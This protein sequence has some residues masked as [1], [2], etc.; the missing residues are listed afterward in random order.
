MSGSVDVSFIQYGVSPVSESAGWSSIGGRNNQ[1]MDA[2]SPLDTRVVSFN[3]LSRNGSKLDIKEASSPMTLLFPY[4]STQVKSNSSS[5]VSSYSRLSFNITCPGKSGHEGDKTSTKAL[6]FHKTSSS[7]TTKLTTVS[8]VARNTATGLAI[9]SVP[10]GS[11]IGFRNI[12]C[13]ARNTS[14]ILC[15][16]CPSI[17]VQPIC[18]FWNETKNVWSSS[19]CFVTENDQFSMSCSCNHTTN[20]AARFVALADMQEDLFSSESLSALSKPEELIRL[21]PHVF[22]IISVISAFV[23]IS[24]IITYDLDVRASRLFYETLRND[25]EVKFLERIE[26]LKGN[27]F[28][29]DRVMDDKIYRLRDKIS[30]ARLQRQAKEIAESEGRYYIGNNELLPSGVDINKFDWTLTK[31]T[32]FQFYDFLFSCFNVNNSSHDALQGRAA[33]NDCKLQS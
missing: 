13:G 25:P 30:R 8:I 27:V 17:I 32:S 20:F 5:I 7:V 21:F 18:A 11:P 16:E 33:E 1:V 2:S 14:F 26:T 23:L 3:L 10:C 22:I 6:S 28:I 9:V 12:T 29:L 24:S 4:K 19:G 31:Q 15:Y